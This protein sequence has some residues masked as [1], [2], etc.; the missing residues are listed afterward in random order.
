MLYAILKEG[1]TCIALYIFLVYNEAT[2]K[3]KNMI[4]LRVDDMEKMFLTELS[5]LLIRSKSDTIRF[6]VAHLYNEV[7]IM[8]RKDAAVFG[9]QE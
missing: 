9:R 8:D 4:T 7:I 3:R 2:M 5:Q 1:T 6:A